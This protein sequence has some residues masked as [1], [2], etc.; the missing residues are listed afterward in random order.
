M[1]QIRSFIA[2]ELPAELKQALARL[3]AQLK[4]GT[5][6]M[7]NMVKHVKTAEQK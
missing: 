2:I 3:E 1:E 6:S 5:K 7:V 4:T